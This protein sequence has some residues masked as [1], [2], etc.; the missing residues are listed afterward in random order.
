MILLRLIEGRIAAIAS[1]KSSWLIALH[2]SCTDEYIL[3]KNSDQVVSEGGSTFFIQEALHSSF[4]DAESQSST[5][6]SL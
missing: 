6:C 5:Q 4:D 2:D 1:L 3:P